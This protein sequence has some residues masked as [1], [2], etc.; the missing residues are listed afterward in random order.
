[1]HS[2]TRC[3]LHLT[4]YLR[5]P[6]LYLSNCL[7]SCQSSVYGLLSSFKC[8]RRPEPQGCAMF[9]LPAPAMGLPV[10]STLL[11]A[12]RYHEYAR[13]LIGGFASVLICLWDKSPRS[14]SAGSKWKC[15]LHFESYCPTDFHG[16]C[17][18]LCFHQPLQDHFPVEVVGGYL[19]P[20]QK[21]VHD[22]L[23]FQVPRLLSG[24]LPV[25]RF[26]INE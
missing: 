1:M 15:I 14:Q 3:F 13:T 7:A 4:K 24:K 21:S 12:Q 25:N 11:L 23:D 10:V 8:L 2:P 22:C 6:F 5:C 17:L 16:S 19:L 20:W 18:G 9:Y 26:G